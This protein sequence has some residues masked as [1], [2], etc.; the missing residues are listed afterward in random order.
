MVSGNVRQ[1]SIMNGQ[2][3]LT[4]ILYTKWRGNMILNVNHP[5]DFYNNAKS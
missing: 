3:S 1:I 4:R 2:L 5:L